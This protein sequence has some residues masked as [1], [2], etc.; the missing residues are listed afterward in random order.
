M[1][2][3]VAAVL[4]AG[5]LTPGAVASS[6]EGDGGPPASPQGPFGCCSLIGS[7]L[8]PEDPADASSQVSAD[9]RGGGWT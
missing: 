3:L 4:S 8:D 6:T 5:L 7:G 2:I 9:H 1:K